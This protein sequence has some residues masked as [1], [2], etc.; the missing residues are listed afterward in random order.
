[1]VLSTA[2]A[3]VAS[4]ITN[5]GTGIL[6][7]GNGSVVVSGNGVTGGCI[8][9]YD[10]GPAPSFC[11]TAGGGDFT[12]QG[13]SSAPFT[14]GQT[15]TIQNLNFNTVN[16]FVD[17]IVVN[18]IGLPSLHF[19][20][21]DIRFNGDTAIGQCTAP[22][23]TQAGDSCTPADS[24][25]QLTNGLADP[26]NHNLVDSAAVSFTVDAWGYKTDS[27]T[28]YNGADLYVGVFSTQQDISGTNIQQMLDTIA[29]GGAVSASW[30]ATF[31]PR[32]VVSS[33]GVVPEPASLLLM[34]AGLIAVGLIKRRTRKS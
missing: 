9:W 2:G 17:F 1:M 29:N 30:S 4:P 12:V 6:E 22:F 20:L 14:T 34:G 5:L 23:T 31:T 10:S 19:D 11:P 27:G 21:K 33:A 3:G 28:N 18:R 8:N 7:A 15:G 32:S 24:P 13:G 26:N 16:P 25:F